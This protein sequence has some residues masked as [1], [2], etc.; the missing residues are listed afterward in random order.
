M[1]H[2]LAMWEELHL[3]KLKPRPP[4]HGYSLGEW[5]PA[6]DRYAERTVEGRWA[7]TGVET[8]ARRRG[9]ITPETP[10]HAVEAKDK[11]R[12]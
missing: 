9:G 7:E 4:W 10:V 8:F 1:E 2:A 5:D 3:P 11:R 12:P 6:W